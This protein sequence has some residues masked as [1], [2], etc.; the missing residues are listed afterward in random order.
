VKVSPTKYEPVWKLPFLGELIRE[1]C[2]VSDGEEGLT[3]EE[4]EVSRVVFTFIVKF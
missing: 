3:D 4:D 2:V 1:I